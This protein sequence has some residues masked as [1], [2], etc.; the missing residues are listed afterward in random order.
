[1]QPQYAEPVDLYAPVPHGSL[2]IM[3][4]ESALCAA[5]A[6]D[7]LWECSPYVADTVMCF[8]AAAS[9]MAMARLARRPG[10]A[11]FRIRLLA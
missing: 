8:M 10:S 6:S 7:A 2:T 11:R 3:R 5:V 1:M 9:Q 4:A